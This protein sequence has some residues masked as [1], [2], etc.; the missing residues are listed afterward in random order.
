MMQS[1]ISAS[2]AAPYAEALMSIAQRQDSVDA[3]GDD[4]RNLRQMLSESSELDRFLT[5]P[6]VSAE[7]KR[8]VLSR[9]T[10]E[11]F[12]DS[13]KNVLMLL[14]DRGRTLFLGAICDRYL[15]LLRELKGIALAEVTSASELTEDN[16][17]AIREKVKSFTDVNDVEVS[18][19]VDP[20]LIGGVVVKVGSQVVDASLRGQLRRLALSLS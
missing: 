4:I 3:I 8:G 1:G 18:V 10:Q 15:T 20:D 16:I 9:L 7:A 12:N 13:T 5:N 14:V 17:N 11:G 2:I 6:I 19:S